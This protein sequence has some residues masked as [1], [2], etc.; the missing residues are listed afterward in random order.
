MLGFKKYIQEGRTKKIGF[1]TGRF[2]PPTKLHEKIIKDHAKQFDEFY[3]VVVEGEKSKNEPKNFLTAGERVK[4]LTRM[5]P[6]NVT[7][8]HHNNAKVW[9]IINKYNIDTLNNEVTLFAGSDRVKSYQNDI[10]IHRGELNTDVEVKEIRR[11][12]GPDNVSATKVRNALMSNDY[13]EYKN[14]VASSLTDEKT[15]ITLRDKLNKNF[16]KVNKIVDY[17]KSLLKNE[18]KVVVDLSKKFPTIKT[19]DDFLNIRSTV[20]EKL[21]KDFG[22][23]RITVKGNDTKNITVA[24]K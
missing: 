15:F 21:E 22:S 3:V 6:R 13:N 9:E 10:E 12:E 20:K 11:V 8:I 18:N 16:E 24:V 1:Y 23:V 5:S 19:K 17:I 14:L 2:Q 7:V 4:F